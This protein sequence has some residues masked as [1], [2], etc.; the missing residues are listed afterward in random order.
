MRPS[1]IEDDFQNDLDR[2]AQD[3]PCV[4]VSAQ[5]ATTIGVSVTTKNGTAWLIIGPDGI[6]V[7]PKNLEVEVRP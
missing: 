4:T 3:H 2:V 1:P 6:I 5:T 7:Q